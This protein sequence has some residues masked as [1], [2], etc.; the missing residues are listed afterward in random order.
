[1]HCFLDET[2]EKPTTADNYS[3]FR[4]KTGKSLRE[5]DDQREVND[6]QVLT[7]Y[8]FRRDITF[9]KINKGFFRAIAVI[10]LNEFILFNPN[11]LPICIDYERILEERYI[12][13]GLKGLVGI[14]GT[15]QKSPLKVVELTVI[16]REKCVENSRKQQSIF[17][18]DDKVCAESLLPGVSVCERDSGNGLIFPM[19]KHGKTKYFLRAVA[20][21]STCSPGQYSFLLFRRCSAFGIEKPIPHSRKI[22]LKLQ[23]VSNTAITIQRKN[24]IGCNTLVFLI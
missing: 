12:S 11:I 20:S 15:D 16:T 18:I 14:W 1:M 13:P 5:Y 21:I 22:C 24:L 9:E 17:F 8:D 2:G 3:Q 19:E 4:V 7:V 23:L 10:T 6:V